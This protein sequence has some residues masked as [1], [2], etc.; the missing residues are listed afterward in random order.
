MPPR[1]RLLLL[2]FCLLGLGAS[3]SAAYVHYRILRDPAYSS[4]CDV[5]ATVSCTAVYESRFGTVRGVPVAVPGVIWFALALLMVG[6]ARPVPARAAAAGSARHRSQAEPAP[7]FSS[8]VASYLFVMSTA[9]LA[10]I[11]YLAYAS[12]FILKAV[13]ILC[14]LTYVAVI[15][16]F[17]VSGS[18]SGD[19]PMRSVPGR[20]LA[21][22]RA[23]AARPLV[24]VAFLLFAAGAVSAVALFPREGSRAA[25]ASAPVPVASASQVSEFE[26]WYSSLP[27]MP[28]IVP[29][30]G[31]QVVVVK[32][33]DYQCPGCAS[34]YFTYKSVFAKYDAERP[35]AVKLVMKDYPLEPEC[36]PGVPQTVHESACEA[37]AAVRMARLK[38]RDAELEEWLYSN[39]SSMTPAS[40]RKAA[41]EIG[42]VD[43]FD[44]QYAKVLESVRRDAQFG[45]QLGV[46]STPTL[47]INGVKVDRV[48]QPQYFDAAIAYELKRAAGNAGR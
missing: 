12:F 1:T 26:R 44:A 13:C 17:L 42:H 32:F 7:A 2:A 25:A 36:N 3:L 39:Q 23:L 33:A 8:N 43:D 22:A 40:V 35:G 15:G 14:L 37:A 45:Q 21:D 10:V 5:N 31:A 4:F 24:L 34:A 9:A 19:V 11:L 47:F 29:N 18:R 41:K 27:H 48:L 16:V 38:K 20:A 28:M 30:D 6:L 46:H